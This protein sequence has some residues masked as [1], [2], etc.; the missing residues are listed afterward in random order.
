MSENAVSKILNKIP[1]I[2][3]LGI[4]AKIWNL[5]EGKNDVQLKL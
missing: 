1:F 5:T 2:I 3:S 4:N